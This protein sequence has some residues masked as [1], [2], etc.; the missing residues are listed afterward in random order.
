MNAAKNLKL[1]GITPD[2]LPVEARGGLRE[3]IRPEKRELSSDL[4][5]FKELIA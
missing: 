4:T 3:V 5:L 2:G 1:L